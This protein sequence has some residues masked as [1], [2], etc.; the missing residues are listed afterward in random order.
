MEKLTQAYIKGAKDGGF[1]V[2][3]MNRSDY[4]STL[5]YAG[6]LPEC[7]EYLH[8]KLGG[9]EPDVARMDALFADLGQS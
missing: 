4:E 5:L 8:K 1:V 7:L 9:G 3:Q 2:Q 6:S